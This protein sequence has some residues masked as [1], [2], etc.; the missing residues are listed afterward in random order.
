MCGQLIQKQILSG[1]QMD[2]CLH[3]NRRGQI[4]IIL[5]NFQGLILQIL[6]THPFTPIILSPQQMLMTDLL[7]ASLLLSLQGQR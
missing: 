2:W 1:S 4:V 7:C 3:G 5:E 6:I